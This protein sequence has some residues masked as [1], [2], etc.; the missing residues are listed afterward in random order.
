MSW[1]LH[2]NVV[3]GR[4]GKPRGLMHE[5]VS[6][7]RRKQTIRPQLTF[8]TCPPVPQALPGQPARARLRAAIRLQAPQGRA[9]EAATRPGTQETPAA[10]SRLHDLRRQRLQARPVRRVQDRLEVRRRGRIRP[11]LAAGERAGYDRGF[12]DGIA[13][14][15][16]D[17][18][19]G[20]VFLGLGIAATLAASV[21]HGLGHDLT[22]AVVA[23]WPAVALIGSYELLMM[24]IRSSQ[25]PADGTPETEHHADL[26]QEQATELF[27]EQLAADRV[28]SVRAIRAQLHVGQPRAKAA[29]LPRHGSGKEGGKSRCVSNFWVGASNQRLR[30]EGAT[31]A[32]QNNHLIWRQSHPAD[33]VLSSAQNRVIGAATTRTHADE[34]TTVP[35]D[36]A[37]GGQV[38][39]LAHLLRLNPPD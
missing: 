32:P 11:R 4:C 13:A 7:S 22:G 39:R 35:V 2:L 31:A 8:G 38:V 6:N 19:S 29:R 15:P 1:R 34:R 9:R 21:A 37:E 20:T 16:R 3:C 18:K 27:A 28:P 23:A 25:V 17:H 14:C 5:C 30:H 10:N 26:L 12:P 24:V 36:A 33:D